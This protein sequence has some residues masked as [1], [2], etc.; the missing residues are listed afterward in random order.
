MSPVRIVGS[1]FDSLP[2]LVRIV[3]GLIPLTVLPS[4]SFFLL[5][6]DSEESHQA[7]NEMD[8]VPVLFLA[9]FL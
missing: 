6:I 9:T 8:I 5:L 4:S 3:I 1:L 7:R 2:H